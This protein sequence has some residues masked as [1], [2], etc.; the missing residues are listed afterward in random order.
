VT[1]ASRYWSS[2]TGGNGVPVPRARGRAGYGLGRR[3]LAAL[4][5]ISLPP[6]PPAAQPP[7]RMT[8]ETIPTGTPTA[9]QPP[10]QA[11]GAL[12]ADLTSVPRRR[13]APPRRGWVL[14]TGLSFAAGF[15]ALAITFATGPGGPS[16]QTAGGPPGTED[17]RT[18]ETE[19]P[20]PGD[21]GNNPP[22]SAGETPTLV[23]QTAVRF[24]A[25]TFPEVA[26]CEFLTGPGTV[27]AEGA[28][29]LLATG[30][31][32]V[33][34]YGATL[35]FTSAGWEAVTKIGTENDA[36]QP[37]TLSIHAVSPEQ[38]AELATGAPITGEPG[39]LLDTT[40][41]IRNDVLGAC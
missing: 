35:T 41:V 20:V 16:S 36:D 37:F 22:S 6:R 31:D 14:A 11:T 25:Q 7:H 13:T 4:L 5:G 18:G 29:V 38:A 33:T 40:S 39:R 26:Q 28:A 12:E 34:R 1:L 21:V 15:V 32:R 9:N 27:P 2:L 24:G 8:T 3:Y 19:L 17:P 10:S 23:P 30:I